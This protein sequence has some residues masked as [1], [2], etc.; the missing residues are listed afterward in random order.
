[1]LDIRDAIEEALLPR[2]REIVADELK[3]E[4][5]SKFVDVNEAAEILRCRPQRIY[6]HASEGKLRRFKDGSRVLFARKDVENL[7]VPSNR[8]NGTS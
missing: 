2:I 5:Q 8:K 4:P 3:K 7:I 1:M 6:N